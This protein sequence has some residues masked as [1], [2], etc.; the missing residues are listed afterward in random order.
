MRA[1][2]TLAATALLLTASAGCERVQT[3]LSG[4]SDQGPALKALR[5]RISDFRARFSEATRQSEGSDFVAILHDGGS[6][7]DAIDKQTETL[8]F[9]DGQ[10]VKI[11]VASARNLLRDARPFVD[12]GDVEGIRGAQVKI[13][14][15]LFDID[16]TLDRAAM[17][18]DNPQKTG[19]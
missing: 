16:N 5:Q 2:A 13:D 3:A 14:A 12:S 4:K 9:M 8:S 11:Q 18:T 10:S 7:L 1:V 15:V 19:S 6:L 17:M